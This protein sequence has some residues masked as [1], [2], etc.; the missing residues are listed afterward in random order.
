MKKESIRILYYVDEDGA[1]IE[2]VFDS[3]KAMK[4]YC[5]QENIPVD[6]INLSNDGWRLQWG[7]YYKDGDD[8]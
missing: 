8:E 5:K 7:V 2:G 4:S 1:Q 3:S 6:A